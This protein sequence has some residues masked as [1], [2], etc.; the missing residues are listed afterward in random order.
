MEFD[1]FE[2]PAIDAFDIIERRNPEY[3]FVEK[4]YLSR[5]RWHITYRLIVRNKITCNFYKVIYSE[6][7]TENN[8]GL[9]YDTLR[10]DRVYPD[11]RTEIVYE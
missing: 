1:S 9:E 8:D 2:L 3:E 6:P 10:F 11:A 7:A 5:G 4:T